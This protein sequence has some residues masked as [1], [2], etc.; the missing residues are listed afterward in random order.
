MKDRP[1]RPLIRHASHATFSRE[2]RR[3]TEAAQV[4]C[5]SFPI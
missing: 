3:K 5:D 1:V 2:G 4:E